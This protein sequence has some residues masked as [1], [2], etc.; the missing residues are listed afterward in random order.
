[1]VV[2]RYFKILI[3]LFLTVNLYAKEENLTLTTYYPSPIGVY[4]ELRSQRLIVGNN[5][6]QN[7][8]IGWENGKINQISNQTN[9]VIE[10]NVGI[11]NFNP[12]A[13]L[14][15]SQDAIIGGNMTVNGNVGIGT[16]PSSARLTV[17]G[18]IKLGNQNQCNTNTA[19]TIRYNTLNQTIEYCNGTEWRNTGKGIINAVA[20][21]T[22][23]IPQPNSAFSIY[24]DL[25]NLDNGKPTVYYGTNNR[26]APVNAN[27]LSGFVIG[28]FIPNTNYKII[29]SF[30]YERLSVKTNST[31][32]SVAPVIYTEG[33]ANSNGAVARIWGRVIQILRLDLAL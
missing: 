32:V 6:Y 33:I 14:E 16:S 2:K 18:G 15:V 12:R 1:M 5:Y 28:K 26:F 22:I 24:V 30:Y 29:T 3:F 4:K 10:G 20:K 11:G 9:V 19:G 8:T 23:E 21:F 13:Q 7:S 31:N 17:A 27:L 25:I